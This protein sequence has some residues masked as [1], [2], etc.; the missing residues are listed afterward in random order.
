MADDAVRAAVP[1]STQV[2]LAFSGGLVGMSEVHLRRRRVSLGVLL[3]D[4]EPCCHR[5]L[6]FNLHTPSLP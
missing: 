6:P 2:E 1:D 5:Q 3:G 4:L